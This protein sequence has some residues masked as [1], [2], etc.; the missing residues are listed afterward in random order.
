[1]TIDELKEAFCRLSPD[2]QIDLARWVVWEEY[3]ETE[4]QR[5]LSRLRHEVQKGIDSSN[6]GKNSR[7]LD[8][9]FAELR[10]KLKGNAAR[11]LKRKKPEL[12]SA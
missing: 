7:P 12:A 8:E 6:G 9:V 3:E 11:A 10:A 4:K 2:D 5:K 1:M